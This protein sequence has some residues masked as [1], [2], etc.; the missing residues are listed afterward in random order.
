MFEPTP[1]THVPFEMDIPLDAEDVYSISWQVRSALYC[2]QENGRYLYTSIDGYA[3]AKLLDDWSPVTKE[4]KLSKRLVKALE[5]R[6]DV[7]LAGGTVSKIGDIIAAHVVKDGVHFDITDTFDWNAGDF[8]DSGSC[9]WGTNREARYILQDNGALALR[10]YNLDDDGYRGIGRCWMAQKSNTWVLFNAYGPSLENVAQRMK[11]MFPDYNGRFV[12]L[13]NWGESAGMVYINRSMGYQVTE[14]E[15]EYR[16]PNDYGKRH[17]DLEIGDTDLTQCEN[18]ERRY[19]QDD[20]SYSENYGGYLC[21]GCTGELSYCERCEDYHDSTTEV[22]V[23][24]TGYRG[25]TYGR[26]FAWCDHCLSDSTQCHD[27]SCYIE[28]GS[29]NLS[30]T[31]VDIDHHVCPQCIENYT[32][33]EACDTYSKEGCEECQEQEEETAEVVA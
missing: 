7:K 24:R 2:N 10:F 19:D 1:I 13:E 8:G 14:K 31:E 12:F 3:V 33:C 28:G 27:C 30:M 26:T 15:V 21:D 6:L 18:C 11:I 4:G 5:K 17:I 32:Y 22:E 16:G 20:M 29:W 23:L 25:D 9:F